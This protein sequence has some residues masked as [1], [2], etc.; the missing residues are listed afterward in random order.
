V[1]ETPELLA[2]ARAAFGRG[3]SGVVEIRAD[4]GLVLYADGRGETCVVGL[5]APA[6]IPSCVWRASEETLMR[7]LSGG[8]A[9]E[10]AYIS[11]RLKI[12][13]DMSVMARL[14]LAGAA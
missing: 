1:S 11:G 2:A 9:L 3:F 10:G 14:E 8:R 12:A 13:G 4:E 7:A 5:E 6:A